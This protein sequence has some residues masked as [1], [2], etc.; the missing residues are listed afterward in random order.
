MAST[1]DYDLEKRRWRW[2]YHVFRAVVV[3]CIVYVVGTQIVDRIAARR[4]PPPPPVVE[5]PPPPPPPPVEVR[6][7]PEPEP[8]PP[9]PPPPPPVVVTPPRP[10]YRLTGNG[11]N[12]R[13]GPGTNHP[14][15]RRVTSDQV[16][17]GTGEIQ[18]E[19][20]EVTVRGTEGT[21]WVFRTLVR[22]GE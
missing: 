14:V 3:L 12:G 13:G 1:R 20:I 11:I 19:W 5:A 9:P 2:S 4:P 15:V 10:T 18:G 17:V 8:P 21:F 7:P 22:P 6:P 16:L